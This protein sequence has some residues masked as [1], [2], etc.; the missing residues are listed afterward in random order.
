MIDMN[1]MKGDYQIQYNH[2]ILKADIDIR[3]L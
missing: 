2:N 1:M 3:K